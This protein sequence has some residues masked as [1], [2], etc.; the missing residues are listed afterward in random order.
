MI[1]CNGGTSID[2]AVNNIMRTD[3][4]AIIITDAED[5]C[6]V[7]TEKAFFIGLEGARF[8]SFDSEVIKQY[9]NR[10]QVVVFD[11]TKIH[12]VDQELVMCDKSYLYGFSLGWFQ[13]P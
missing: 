10:G 9:S 2:V 4:N 8:T 11:G 6:R 12:K 13:F 5:R 1:D 7:F 3:K